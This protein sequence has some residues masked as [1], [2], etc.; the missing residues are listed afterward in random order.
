MKWSIQQGLDGVITDD[1]KRFM[2]VCEE[3]EGGKRKVEITWKQWISVLWINLMVVIFGIIFSWKYGREGFAAAAAKKKKKKRKES[4]C[5][6]EG[7]VG[8]PASSVLE[9]EGNGEGEKEGG[10]R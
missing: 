2:D 10:V 4:G 6:E 1:P 8:V 7:K 5:G 9:D 3:W